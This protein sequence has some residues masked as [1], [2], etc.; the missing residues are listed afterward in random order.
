MP[1]TSKYGFIKVGNLKGECQDSRHEGWIDVLDWS[2]GA[3]NHGSGQMGSGSGTGRGTVQDFMFRKLV[4][5]TSTYIAQNL[6]QGEHFDKATFELLKSGGKNPLVYYKVEFDQVFISS[7][8]FGGDAEGGAFTET[9]T[10]N[11]RKFK[12][13]YTSQNAQGGKGESSDLGWD[14][15]KNLEV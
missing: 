1:Q 3:T 5:T 13:T 9:V 6:L 7:L 15:A 14:T 10:F 2:W 12:A 4:D 8:L 11:F